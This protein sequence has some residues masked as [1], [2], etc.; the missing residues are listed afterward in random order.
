[1]RATTT[2][3]K[4]ALHRPARHRHRRP[5]PA[6]LPL[7]FLLGAINS[8]LQAYFF[9]TYIINHS[10]GSGLIHSTPGS[11]GRLIV[12]RTNSETVQKIVG[13]VQQLI[14][15]DA[16]IRKTLLPSDHKLLVRRAEMLSE[17][18]DRAMFDAYGL[19]KIEVKMIEAKVIGR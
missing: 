11:Q 17:G 15:V 16:S 6:D 12:P 4:S 14:G 2:S 1:M 18:I 9:S 13:L 3:S 7:E 10:L 5:S 19:S 8:K